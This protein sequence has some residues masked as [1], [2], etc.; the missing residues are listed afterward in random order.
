MYR[1]I[2]FEVRESHA[3]FPYFER[4]CK[5]Y[6]S[7]YNV[8]NYLIRNTMTGLKKTNGERTPNEKEVLLKVFTGIRDANTGRKPEK[9]FPFPTKEHWMLDYYRINAILK[10]KNDPDYQSLPAQVNQEAIKDCIEAWRGYFKSLQSYKQDP[11]LFKGMPRI[12]KY[13]RS[14]RM[15]ATFTNQICKIRN[16]R[17]QF[18]KTREKLTVGTVSDPAWKFC[19][20]QVKPYYGRYKVLVIMDDGMDIQELDKRP[21]RILGIDPGISNFAAIANNIGVT[22]VVIKG[23][24]MKARNQ[25]FN[26]RIAALRSVVMTPGTPN[27]AIKDAESQIQ[28]LCRSRDRFFH[29]VFYKIS[30]RIC[31]YAAQNRIDTIVAGKN[32]GWKQESGLG[33]QN[34]QN[35]VQIPHAK[36]LMILREVCKRYGIRYLEQEESYT[37]KASLVDMD[38]I[39]AYGKTETVPVFQGKRIKRGLYRSKDRMILNA[40]INGSGNIIRKAV[41]DAF[42]GITDFHYLYSTE[43]WNFRTFYQDKK[44]ASVT[45]GSCRS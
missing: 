12:P 24:F 41:P 40:D 18:P 5:N 14:D 3:L 7:M 38:Q 36:F 15:T 39:P 2:S 4:I 11:S 32:D 31:R 44:V 23:G 29:D 30:H 21:E 27:E 8:T 45:G 17:L 43:I 22:P 35:F 37:S 34:N 13:M 33:K 42:S 9:R 25:Y 20:V 6:R 1:T 26:K 10:G 28:R 19:E 16:G